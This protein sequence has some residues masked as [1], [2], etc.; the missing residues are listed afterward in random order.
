MMRIF[1]SLACLNPFENQVK[2]KLR[3]KGIQGMKLS[4][5]GE[6]VI[7]L[8]QLQDIDQIEV[9][10]IEEN[11]LPASS[12]GPPSGTAYNG[13]LHSKATPPVS[14]KDDP[15]RKYIKRKGGFVQ[16]LL[17]QWLPGWASRQPSLPVTMRDEG[18][19]RRG[20]RRAKANNRNLMFV[21]CALIL[22]LVL[23]M[24]YLRAFRA[25]SPLSQE[26]HDAFATE[27]H[28]LED[29]HVRERVFKSMAARIKANANDAAHSRSEDAHD[30][31]DD[32]TE[33]SVDAAT[34]EMHKP[35]VRAPTGQKELNPD[36]RAQEGS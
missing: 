28:A 35:V 14:H 19:G 32:S 7:D 34:I 2:A 9:M 27:K 10:P 20:R 25:M 1:I 36:L 18:Q 6:D 24:F 12:F 23:S 21:L 13:G 29:E 3:I 15:N 4:T 16:S 26:G 31:V 17:R 5:T 33:G 11:T 22:A 8:S 30:A